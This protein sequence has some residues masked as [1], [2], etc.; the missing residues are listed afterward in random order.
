MIRIGLQFTNASRK[1]LNRA[2]ASAKRA[3]RKNGWSMI[4]LLAI[5]TA[6]SARKTAAV[7]K[8]G[9]PLMRWSAAEQRTTGAM[10]GVKVDSKAFRDRLATSGARFTGD[11][12][13]FN[14]IAFYETYLKH[15][16]LRGLAKACWSSILRRMNVTQGT[17]VD[18]PA[19]WR[20]ARWVTWVRFQKTGN[21]F[22]EFSNRLKYQGLIQPSILRD[23]MS[24]AERSIIHQE[25]KRA[26][27]ETERAWRTA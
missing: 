8:R 1:T 4:N 14:N 2:V 5:R 7:S 10:Y 6:S 12:V 22:I 9:R 20:P 26:K 18:S 16:R 27:R 17:Q 23:A 11:W 19:L 21:M 13:L 15:I 25:A 3:T 24:S